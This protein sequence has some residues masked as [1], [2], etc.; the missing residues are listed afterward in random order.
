MVVLGISLSAYQSLGTMNN[1][2]S[3]QQALAVGTS[4]SVTN[5]LDPTKSKDG[6]YSVQISDFKEGDTAKIILFD[7]AGSVIT[8]RT[9]EKSPYQ[10]NF[11]ITSSGQYKLEIQ[12]VGQRDL[13]VLGIIG[14]YPQGPTLLDFLDV[15]VLIVGLSGLAVG[16]LYLVKQRR[17]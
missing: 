17:I 2:S 10:E 6:V 1:L 9:T 5:N 16:M 4:M 8:T 12:N 11:T 13:Q 7:P 3:Q 14:Y 15:V